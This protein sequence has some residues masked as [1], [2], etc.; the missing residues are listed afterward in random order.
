MQYY[1]PVICFDMG[2]QAE[3]VSA[4]NKGIVVKDVGE[5]VDVIMEKS[6]LWKEI[7]VYEKS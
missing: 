5:M 3:K 7:I 4:Y 6:K 1:I 2:A